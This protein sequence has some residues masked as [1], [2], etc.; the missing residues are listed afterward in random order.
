MNEYTPDRWLAV[1]ITLDDG[2]SLFKILGSWYGGYLGSDSW[3][4]SSGATDVKEKEDYYEVTNFS[5]S[6]Y[7]CYK[8]SEGASAYV[9]GLLD[10]WIRETKG[11]IRAVKMED[12]QKGVSK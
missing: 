11:K 6:V 2:A 9:L 12:I 5:G 3:R 1:Q 8:R 7:R 10:M 4:I